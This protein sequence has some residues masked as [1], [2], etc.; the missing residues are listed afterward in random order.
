M[1][2]FAFI[3]A[4]SLMAVPA[5]AQSI[6]TV[7]VM[8]SEASDGTDTPLAPTED[9]YSI[10]VIGDALAGGLGAG[11]SRMAELE[12]GFEVVNRFQEI[13][14]IARPEVYDWAAG[15]PNIMEGKQFDAVVVL[16][17]ANDRQEIRS[18]VIRYVFNTPEWI[19][20]YKAQTARLIEVLNANKVKIFWVA[21]PPMGDALY[22]ADMKTLAGLQ[23]QEVDA[24]GGT[25][26]DLRSAFLNPDGTYT[27]KG[28]DDTGEV[29]KLRARDGVTFFKQGNNRFGQLLLAAIKKEKDTKPN[30]VVPETPVAAAA[31]S[32]TPETV[33][34]F[35]QDLRDGQIAV[36]S[37]EKPPA[38]A[39]PTTSAVKAEVVSV[40]RADLIAGSAAEK[41]FVYGEAKPAPAGRF[42]DFTAP[43]TLP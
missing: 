31:P 36:F 12:T 10:L 25:Y 3:V 20:A 18:G 34:T 1:K 13:S 27:D 4:A 21:I 5:M 32:S 30:V 24:G 35:G 40:S 28:A 43:Q 9:T 33:P 41:L 7:P 29:R 39:I 26:I 15:V 38:N 37:P 6:V 8:G 2:F 23:K 42:D 16:L 11:L 22:D 14:G 17:G 19:K